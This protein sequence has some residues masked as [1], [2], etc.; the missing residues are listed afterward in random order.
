MDTN[1][2]RSEFLHARAATESSVEH[3]SAEDMMLQPTLGASPAKWHLAHTSW[4]FET[5]ILSQREFERFA[6]HFD[7]LFNSY[8]LGVGC[9]FDRPSRGML[10]RPSLAEVRD[11]RNYVTGTIAE[12]LSAG[13]LSEVELSLIE[14]GINHEEQ[15]QELILSDVKCAF[16]RNP[17]RPAYFSAAPERASKSSLR[18]VDV[19]G[20]VVDVGATGEGFSFDNEGPRHKVLLQPFSIASRPVTNGEFLAFVADGGY[21]D[22]RLWLADGWDWNSESK[23]QHPQYWSRD[24]EAFKEF[25]LYGMRDL[26]VNAIAT[27]ISFFEADAFATWAGKR[28]PTEFEWEHAVNHLRPL[29]ATLREDGNYLAALPPTDEAI[30][31]IGGVWEWTSSNYRPYPGYTIPKGNVGEYNGKFM[32]SQYV[33][34]GGSFA[35][36]RRH[37]RASYR[38][39][40][41]ADATWQFSGFRLVADL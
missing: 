10:S 7:S 8:Y 13:R 39:F 38:N 5:F 4:F 31:F 28:L 36:P 29:R 14:L 19:P 18:Y 2:L 9:P 15:H 32:N 27:H 33:L 26:D 40:F 1:A 35:T 12:L 6:P 11:Y 21:R 30:G 23:R 17:L 16:L 25:T 34:R 37:I 41:H 22:H 3:L 20:G 24:G